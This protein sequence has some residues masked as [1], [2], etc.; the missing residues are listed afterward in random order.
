M[1]GREGRRAPRLSVVLSICM[2]SLVGAAIL[3][4][5]A[6]CGGSSN[7]DAKDG[8]NGQDPELVV[9]GARVFATNCASCHAIAGRPHGGTTGE[10]G[11]SFDEVRP[12][13]SLI[14]KRIDVGAYGMQSFAGE[15]TENEK[16]AVTSYLLA[17][18]GRDVPTRPVASAADIAA[19]EGGF[20]RYCQSCHTIG[21]NRRNGN[22]TFPGTNFNNVAV[23]SERAQQMIDRGDWWMPAMYERV[24]RTTVH[25]IIAY[26]VSA[27]GRGR[28]VYQ[29]P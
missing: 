11:V 10:Y 9:A 25:D 14:A 28:D 16:A 18:A 2:A 20:G 7:S 4:G 22:P 15:L 6:S 27:S 3:F 17:T 13:A 29:E 23:S 5:L 1:T 21:A 24:P 19:G 26:V 8:A 12:K